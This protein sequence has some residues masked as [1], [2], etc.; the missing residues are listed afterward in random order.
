MDDIERNSY[1]K[2]IEKRGKEIKKLKETIKV[3]ES[4]VKLANQK[5][6]I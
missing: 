3:L 6:E 2:E 4:Q 1:L 5:R